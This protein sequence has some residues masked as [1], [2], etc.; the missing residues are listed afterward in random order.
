MRYSKKRRERVRVRDTKQKETRSRE[1]KKGK[2]RAPSIIFFSPFVSFVRVIFACA[3]TRGRDQMT[4]PKRRVSCVRDK[5]EKIFLKNATREG[6]EIKRSQRERERERE[7]SRISHARYTKNIMFSLF[8]LF[9]FFRAAIIG[10]VALFA[11]VVAGGG[12]EINDDVS[13]EHI[14]PRD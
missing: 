1:R 2:T 14:L 3:T 5:G 10:L 8:Y 11:V 9:F 6:F 4:N 12:R 13:F 7:R